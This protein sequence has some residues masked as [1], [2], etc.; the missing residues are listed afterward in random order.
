MGITKTHLLIICCILV[1]LVTGCIFDDDSDKPSIAG[2]WEQYNNANGN[3]IFRKDNSYYSNNYGRGEYE[4]SGD[5][6]TL[7]SVDNNNTI[8]TY[9]LKFVLTEEIL[10]LIVDDVNFQDY[11]RIAE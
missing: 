10:T 8:K 6:L 1:W 5:T 7:K 11:I 3:F 4:I 9:I 2:I